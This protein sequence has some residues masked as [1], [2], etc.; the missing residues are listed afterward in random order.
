MAETALI[1]GAGEGLSASLARL[2]AKEGMR[3][4]VAARNPDKLAPL[5]K[6]TGAQAFAC[7]AADEQQVSKL[8]D[9]VAK[10]LGD[11]EIVVF[12]P[13]ARARGP[14]VE[15]V[16]ADVLRALTVS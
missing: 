11:P 12:N 10:K 5:C 4:A 6:A 2:F 9:D 15:L 3:V 16:A 13:S 7:D 8:F 14:L 1:V